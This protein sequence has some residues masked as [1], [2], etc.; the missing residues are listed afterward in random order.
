MRQVEIN[1]KK[2]YRFRKMKTKGKT[3]FLF[4]KPSF[5]VGMGSIFSV[6][7]N[8]FDYVPFDAQA[9][10]KAISSDWDIV[11]QDIQKAKDSF[12]KIEN[13]NNDKKK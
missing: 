13:L 5:W 3:N 10:A 9:D 11:G 4:S 12:V 7:G 6:G 8:Y 1:K 2:L